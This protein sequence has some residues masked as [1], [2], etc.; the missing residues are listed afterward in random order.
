MRRRIHKRLIALRRGVLAGLALL[1]FL[2]SAVGLPL[3][4][5]S[6]TASGSGEEPARVPAQVRPCGCV[7][8]A[9]G[10]R[11]LIGELVRKCHGLDRL[12]SSAM[13]ALPTAPAVRCVI[14]AQAA[15]PASLSAFSACHTVFRPACTSSTLLK[16]SLVSFVCPAL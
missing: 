10:P 11:W 4:L 2:A 3:P 8:E 1:G 5:S 12:L 7:V 13:I 14:D 16:A 15:T 9:D 6:A